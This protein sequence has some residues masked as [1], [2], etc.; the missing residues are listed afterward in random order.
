ME[1][2]CSAKFSPSGQYHGVPGVV[3]TLE[4]TTHCTRPPSKSVPY[5]ALSPHWAPYEDDCP[6]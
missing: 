4:R 3:A 1:S 6:A 5:L 2:D